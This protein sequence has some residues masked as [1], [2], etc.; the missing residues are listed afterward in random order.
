MLVRVFWPVNSTN[1]YL[2]PFI[3]L[4]PLM[5]GDVV[6]TTVALRLGYSEINP[7][8]AQLS[9]DPLLHLGLKIVI[10]VLLFSL[11]IYLYSVETRGY[12]PGPDPGGI[13]VRYMKGAIFV[14]IFIDCLIYAGAFISNWLIILNH[15]DIAGMTVP[16]G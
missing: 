6:T 15:P 10:P 11:C 2:W 7:L 3:F 4:I 5:I 14:I 1:Y 9:G 8:V 16:A 12:P 13:L